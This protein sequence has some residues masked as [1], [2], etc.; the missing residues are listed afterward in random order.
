MERSWKDS[1]VSLIVAGA[2][3]L[4]GI[5][6]ST[7]TIPVFAILVTLAVALTAY[8]ALPVIPRPDIE[9]FS[10]VKAPAQAKLDLA[11]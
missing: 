7:G 5:G 2:A 11:A 4:F 9:D 10:L 1:A 8:L 3:V 6:A